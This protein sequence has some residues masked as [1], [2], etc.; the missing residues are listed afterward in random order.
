MPALNE[1]LLALD[2]DFIERL[3][4]MWTARQQTICLHDLTT[5]PEADPTTLRILQRYCYTPL[6]PLAVSVYAA[7]LGHVLGTYMSWKEAQP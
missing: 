4:T 6:L 1:T 3:D 7:Q 5:T 2:K